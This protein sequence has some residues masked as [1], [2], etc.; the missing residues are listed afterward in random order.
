MTPEDLE[1]LTLE[2]GR[3]GN[4]AGDAMCYGTHWPFFSWANRGDDRL[5]EANYKAALAELQEVEDTGHSDGT[6]DLVDADVRHWVVGSLSQLWV[7]MKDDSGDFTP[8][9]VK[10]AEL[11]SALE[12]YP[13]LDE[14]LLSELEWEDYER[15]LDDALND[16]RDMDLEDI[17]PDDMRD[18]MLDAARCL[19]GDT[20]CPFPDVD[21]DRV[22]E[23]YDRVLDEAINA[24]A[25]AIMQA[26]R[27]AEAATYETDLLALA[28]A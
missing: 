21:Y 20:D 17:L 10:V 16:A 27:E 19:Y 11:C 28:G 26:D 15:D 4:F 12:D 3:P 18:L 1:R 5:S 7:R 13:V 24:Y 23:A 8:M 2:H 14:D 9:W 6:P 25:E 22:A